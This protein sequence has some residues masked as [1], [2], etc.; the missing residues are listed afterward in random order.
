M[1]NL[2]LLHNIKLSTPGH[3]QGSKIAPNC[4]KHNM[5][6]EIYQISNFR[7]ITRN[8]CTDVTKRLIIQ[9]SSMLSL[10]TSWALKDGSEHI[11]GVHNYLTNFS[12]AKSV[13]P[14]IYKRETLHLFTKQAVAQTP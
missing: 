2:L 13:L 6:G 5:A 8:E 9:K 12:I 11:H 14:L 10:V 1:A 3:F 4:M 7:F